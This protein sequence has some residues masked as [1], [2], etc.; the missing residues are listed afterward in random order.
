MHRSEGLAAMKT[1]NKILLLTLLLVGTLLAKEPAIM[2]FCVSSFDET[3]DDF[4]LGIRAIKRIN[5]DSKWK[6][7][8]SLTCGHPVWKNKFVSTSWSV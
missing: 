2:H 3:A 7:P 6:W 1:V 4:D 5:P 8:D